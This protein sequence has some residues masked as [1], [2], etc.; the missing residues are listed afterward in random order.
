MVQA[1]HCSDIRTGALR[2][3]GMYVC[4]AAPYL[5]CLLLHDRLGSS[6]QK[7]CCRVTHRAHGAGLQ[8]CASSHLVYAEQTWWM[9]LFDSSYR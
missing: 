7:Q 4:A 1:L 9:L 2:A 3:W 6:A 5:L 8:V